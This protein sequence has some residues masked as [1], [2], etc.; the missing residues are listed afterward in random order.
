MSKTNQRIRIYSALEVANI[1]G[2]VNQTAINWIR[3]GHLNAFTTPGG[4]YRVYEEDLSDFLTKRGMRNSINAGK[5]PDEDNDTDGL[6]AYDEIVLIIDNDRNANDSL[7][8]WL[9]MMFPGFAV[10]QAYDGF[11]AGQQLYQARPGL[12]FLNV[13]LPGINVFNL[14]KKFKEDA[15]LG[16]PNVIALVDND[17]AGALQAAWSDAYFSRPLDL[18]KLQ[19]TIRD[20]AKQAHALVTA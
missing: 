6:N 4:Q 11:E 2:V 1:C 15:S 9:K 16:N 17:A 19:E 8:T 12:V 13:D 7:S 18:E 5:D 3:H 20:T 14:A 10:L